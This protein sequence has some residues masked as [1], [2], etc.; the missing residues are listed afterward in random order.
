MISNEKKIKEPPL[1]S[2]TFSRL[3]YTSSSMYPS[4]EAFSGTFDS[5]RYVASGA[6]ATTRFYLN[7]AGLKSVTSIPAVFLWFNQKISG[8]P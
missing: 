5:K 2:F 6:S 8:S 3:R 1:S 7:D 4:P